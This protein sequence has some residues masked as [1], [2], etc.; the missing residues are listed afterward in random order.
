MK[1]EKISTRQ[2]QGA[3][4]GDGASFGRTAST[5]SNTSW[6]SARS[7]DM[8]P[9]RGIQSPLPLKRESPPLPRE[10]AD[11]C[12]QSAAAAG[13]EG[14]RWQEHGLAGSLPI[15]S[16]QARKTL[17]PKLLPIDSTQTA[18]LPGSSTMAAEESLAVPPPESTVDATVVAH[19]APVA[20]AELDS[21][22]AVAATSEIQVEAAA[23]GGA[24]MDVPYVAE[25]ERAKVAQL[26]RELGER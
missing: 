22:T 9:G 1:R 24:A 14:E 5:C 25:T 7:A 13:C 11:P 8:E 12:P 21:E 17:P 2:L 4:G 26:S 15:P 16:S 6:T 3:M 10:S 19:H 18:E 23:E 20:G